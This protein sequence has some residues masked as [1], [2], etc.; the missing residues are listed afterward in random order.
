MAN[1]WGLGYVR[2]Q[3]SEKGSA[4]IYAD[5]VAGRDCPHDDDYGAVYCRLG[6]YEAGC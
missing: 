4:G 1:D 6:G 5:R 3:T 2:V